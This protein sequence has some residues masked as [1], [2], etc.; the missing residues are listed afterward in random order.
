M[1]S[2][3]NMG[4][5]AWDLET[6][7]YDHSELAGNF[8]AIDQHDHSPGK[9]RRVPRTGIADSAIDGT[10]LAINAVNPDIHIP[11]LSI[12]QP[13][14]SKNSVGTDQIIDGAVGS[15]EIADSSIQYRHLSFNIIP[16]GTIN[17]WYRPNANVQPPT[18]WEICDGRPWSSVTNAWG[19]TTGNL[20]DFR[21]RFP[22]GANTINDIG[23]YGGS[24]SVDLSHS[25]SVSP[26]SHTISPHVHGINPDGSHK[27]RWITIT[28]SNG[29]PI[30]FAFT[31]AMSRGT[32]VPGSVGTR[33]ALYVPDLNRSEYFGENVSAPMETVG[34]HSHGGATT[35]NAP[36]QTSA[37]ATGT[38]ASLGGVS[39]N[40]PSLTVLFIIKVI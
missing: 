11:D 5:T 35:G 4:L 28:W 38:S 33:Q 13:K 15:A 26:H 24:S 3:P 31:D 12:H 37:D 10:K 20:P 21:N 6:D 29:Q 1:Y 19:L 7:P 2:T 39:L 18:G 8:N 14:L 9:G 17:M 32:A 23:A 34:N 40:P 25:H 22:F 27:H 30:G 36:Q 16:I